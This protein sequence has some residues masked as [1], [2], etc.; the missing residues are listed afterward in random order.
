MIGNG[1]R[2]LAR[3]GAARNATPSAP[4]LQQRDSTDKNGT[5]GVD[6]T[7][8]WRKHLARR[9]PGLYAGRLGELFRRSAEIAKHTV[10]RSMRQ[11]LVKEQRHRPLEIP[12]SATGS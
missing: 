1:R 6:V 9:V 5:T 12:S 8:W 10:Q 2:V 4:A 11:N 3:R 7:A